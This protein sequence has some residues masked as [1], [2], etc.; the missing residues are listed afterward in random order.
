VKLHASV[1]GRPQLAIAVPVPLD[2][3]TLTVR[4][5]VETD[6]ALGARVGLGGTAPRLNT[7]RVSRRSRTVPVSELE[8]ASVMHENGLFCSCC[9]SKK[10]VNERVFPNTNLSAAPGRF[11]PVMVIRAAFP[12]E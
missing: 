8:T 4:E 3:L 1:A 12:S 11:T 6:G 2:C 7:S 9:V 10:L 5:K